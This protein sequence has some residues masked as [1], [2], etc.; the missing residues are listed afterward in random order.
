M[1]LIKCPHCGKATPD[2]ASKC[3]KCGQPLA[4]E[5]LGTIGREQL[6][7]GNL[8]E[9]VKQT[10]L[11]EGKIAA[12]KRLREGSPGL[13]LAEAKEHVEGLERSLPPGMVPKAKGCTAV[14]AVAGILCAVLVLWLVF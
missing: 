4:P 6:P 8:D 12:I 3:R 7:P 14:F 1:G 11:T 2:D 10:L 9:L 13:G 5:Q